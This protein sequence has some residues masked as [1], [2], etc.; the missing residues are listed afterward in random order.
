MVVHLIL[1]VIKRY[2]RNIGRKHSTC[3]MLH[4]FTFIMYI[5]YIY[6]CVCVCVFVCVCA[7]L[8]LLIIGLVTLWQIMKFVTTSNHFLLIYTAFTFCSVYKYIFCVCN[9]LILTWHCIFTGLE[10]TL[11]YSPDNKS[12]NNMK[13]F[14]TAFMQYLFSIDKSP[15]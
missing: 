1:H 8:I 13:Q 6:V 12:Q 3:L 14:K 9:V 15:L 2:D 5:L 4:H 11:M 7:C 10:L